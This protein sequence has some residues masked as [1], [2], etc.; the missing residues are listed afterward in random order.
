M[1]RVSWR[2]N[3]AGQILKRGRVF[4]TWNYRRCNATLENPKIRPM[5]R[6]ILTH[7]SEPFLPRAC[8]APEENKMKGIWSTE[9]S[10][11]SESSIFISSIWE[12]ENKEEEREG[13][14]WKGLSDNTL[15]KELPGVS[16]QK[17]HTKTHRTPESTW[18]S[19]PSQQLLPMQSAARKAK[20]A[21]L[22][23]SLNKANFC[24]G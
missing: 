4:L 21:L 23:Y 12:R 5:S 10:G 7:F 18:V 9:E 20:D 3:M 6:V 13:T 24:V 17:T 16:R 1:L 11:T 22:L 14:V 19:D 15:S 2:V 8:P